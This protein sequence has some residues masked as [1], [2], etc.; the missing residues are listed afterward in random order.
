MFLQKRDQQWAA[1]V[2]YTR[3]YARTA[4]KTLESELVL[5]ICSDGRIQDLD[6]VQARVLW[7]KRKTK[8]FADSNREEVAPAGK[9]KHEHR[10]SRYHMGNELCVCPEC[11]ASWTY[12]GGQWD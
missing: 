9:C 1:Y 8:G 12:A 10:I 5:V 6:T 2:P 4:L 3:E 11:L 7:K